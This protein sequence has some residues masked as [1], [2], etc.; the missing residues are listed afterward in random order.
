MLT[1]LQMRLYTA[2]ICESEHKFT[3][4]LLRIIKGILNLFT[5]SYF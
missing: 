1:T 2:V 5:D 4:F 3:I